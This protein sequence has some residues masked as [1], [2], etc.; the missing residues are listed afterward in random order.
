[1]SGNCRDNAGTGDTAMMMPGCCRDGGEA[2]GTPE[3]KVGSP[4]LF[5]GG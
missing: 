2:V 1:M 4:A 3:I 5:C